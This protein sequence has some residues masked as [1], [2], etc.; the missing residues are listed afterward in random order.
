M[1]KLFL[2]GISLLIICSCENEYTVT[3]TD[4]TEYTGSDSIES[5]ISFYPAEKYAGYKSVGKPELKLRFVTGKNFSGI[6][7]HLAC[8]KFI[9][10]NELIVRFDSIQ[11]D[12][13]PFLETRPADAYVD[14]PENVNTITLINGHAIDKY[15]VIVTETKV[16]V[17]S[18]V[19]NHTSVFYDKIFRYPENTFIVA[20][21]PKSTDENLYT[22]FLSILSNEISLVGYEF[23]GEGKIPYPYYD[24]PVTDCNAAVFEYANE[25]DFDRAGE[26]LEAYTLEHI[27]PD[28]GKGI[29][30]IGWNNKRF[31]SYSFYDMPY[32]FEAILLY[33]PLRLP[34]V[35]CN[36]EINVLK[37]SEGL[38]MVDT[39]AINTYPGQINDSIYIAMNLPEELNAVGSIIRL[40]LRKPGGM[41]GCYQGEM[42]IFPAKPVIYITRAERNNMPD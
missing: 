15:E 28:K 42:P 40:N 24:N 30:M 18:I 10:K 29:S 37:F 27:P 1:R 3:G 2:F 26:L 11:N 16:E 8:T 20:G 19:N 22:D 17:Y 31:L 39:I 14:L 25:S 23:H 13:T 5:W 36:P 7:H 4:Y 35:S 9:E 12:M 32:E 6:K 41:P 34:A 21:W 33:K 38:D